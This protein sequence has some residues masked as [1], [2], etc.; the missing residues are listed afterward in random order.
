MFLFWGA[1]VP[2]FMGQGRKQYTDYAASPRMAEKYICSLYDSF[3]GSAGNQQGCRQISLPVHVDRLSAVF[4][5]SGGLLRGSPSCEK[6]LRQ[7][8]MASLENMDGQSLV[9]VTKESQ[10]Y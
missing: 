4:I 9:V 10:F 8:K 6:N 5:A 1:L 7:R 3:H 2:D